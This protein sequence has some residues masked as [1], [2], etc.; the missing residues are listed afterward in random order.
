MPRWVLPLV[1]AAASC[2]MV[3]SAQTYPAKA[4]RVI[5]PAAPADSCDV[6]SRLVGPKVSERLGQQLVI[7]NRPGAGGQ[8]GLQLLTQAPPDGYTIACGQGGNMVIVPL[9]YQKVAY[10]TMRDFAPIALVA[11]NFLGLVVHPSVPFRNAA[12]LIS[13]ARANPGKLT[14]GSTGE[15][16]FLH[17]ATELFSRQGGFKYLHVPLKSASAIHVEVMAG[18]LDA[19]FGSFISLHPHV[20]SGR[21]KLLGIARAT[22]A[23]RIIR[24]FRRSPNRCP[25][26]NQAAGL[27]SSAPL[28]FQKTSSH[29]SIRK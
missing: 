23:R 28:R 22:R 8:L 9:A 11:S 12:E 21:L 27:D 16:A 7:D 5:I 29:C 6:L 3:A 25:A 18:R 26:T 13:Y 20:V 4:I 10:D 17:F 2:S 24:I 1:L 14:F 19:S 15:G